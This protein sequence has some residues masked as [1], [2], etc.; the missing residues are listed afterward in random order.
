MGTCRNYA[1]FATRFRRSESRNSCS[2][3]NQTLVRGYIV[4]VYGDVIVGFRE[5]GVEGIMLVING[6]KGRY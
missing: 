1:L 6:R 2:A 5:T 3:S 4:L